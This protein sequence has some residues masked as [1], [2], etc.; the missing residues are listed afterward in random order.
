M[1]LLRI[2]RLPQSLDK[3]IAVSNIGIGNFASEQFPMKACP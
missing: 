2:R 3:A 1:R